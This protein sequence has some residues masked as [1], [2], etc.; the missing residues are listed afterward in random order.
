MRV[1]APDG[2]GHSRFG[3][4]R[5]PGQCCLCSPANRG[6]EP[7]ARP[8]R[9]PGR[10]LRRAAGTT[11]SGSVILDRDGVQPERVVQE[12]LGVIQAED[13]PTRRSF[14]PEGLGSSTSRTGTGMAPTWRGVSGTSGSPRG[15]P[16]APLSDLS[17]RGGR[18]CR[19]K[20]CRCPANRTWSAQMGDSLVSSDS[21]DSFRSCSDLSS[22]SDD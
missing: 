11:T 4:P 1:A 5:D 6:G 10:R 2:W 15:A 7:P 19:G 13:G 22:A 17:D 14:R 16:S 20:S 3:S 9:P 12:V 21:C 18:G 8:W